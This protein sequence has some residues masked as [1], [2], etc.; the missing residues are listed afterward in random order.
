MKKY[1]KGSDKRIFSAILVGWH[2]MKSDQRQESS[3]RLEE[4]KA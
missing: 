3:P 2:G 4:M 1:R